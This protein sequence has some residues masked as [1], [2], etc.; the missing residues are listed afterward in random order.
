MPTKVVLGNKRY[1]LERYFVWELIVSVLRY[2]KP[3]K[4]S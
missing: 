4:F 3:P 2:S 1:L